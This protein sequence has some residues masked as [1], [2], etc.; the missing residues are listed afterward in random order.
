MFSFGLLEIAQDGKLAASI[1]GI[2]GAA[3]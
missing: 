3:L 1:Y 2:D